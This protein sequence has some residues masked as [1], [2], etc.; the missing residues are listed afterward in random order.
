[1]EEFKKIVEF[2][3]Y[4][5]SNGGN[6]KNTLTNKIIKPHNDKGFFRINLSKNGKIIHKKIHRLVAEAFLENIDNKKYIKHIDNDKTNNNV[7]NLCWCNYQE[8][9][10]NNK[11]LKSSNTSITNGVRF[12]EQMNNWQAHINIDDIHVHLGYF[13]NIDDA[14]KARIDI[15]KKLF[16]NSC[17]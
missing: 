11:L 16:G 13:E 3:N 12:N 4:E 17:E 15:V 2:D 14:K 5:I 8:K 7:N 1:M 9:Q 10:C 6:V